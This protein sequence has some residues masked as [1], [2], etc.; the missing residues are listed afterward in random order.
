MNNTDTSNRSATGLLLNDVP[1][2]N[3][4]ARRRN[5]TFKSIT[6]KRELFDNNVEIEKDGGADSIKEINN[7]ILEHID[8]QETIGEG[9]ID[10]LIRFREAQEQLDLAEQKSKRAEVKVDGQQA[11]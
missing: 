7:L 1:D 11:S 8:K 9:E 3:S 6:L 5:H 2:I 10:K 4:P